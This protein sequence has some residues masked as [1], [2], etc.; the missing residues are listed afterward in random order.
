MSIHLYSMS[1]TLYYGSDLK[2][3]IIEKRYENTISFKLHIPICQDTLT[4]GKTEG[5]IYG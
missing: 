4:V 1:N 5:K 2:L 3:L